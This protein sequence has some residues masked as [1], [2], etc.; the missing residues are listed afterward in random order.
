MDRDNF[1]GKTI[2]EGKEY[3]K[4]ERLGYHCFSKDHN[5]KDCESKYRCRIEYCNKRHHSLTCT[6]NKIKS[7]QVESE[8]I[9]NNSIPSNKVYDGDKHNN[10]TYMQILPINLSNGDKTFR[11]NALLDLGSDST[12]IS[13]TLPDKLN[14]C[15]AERSLTKT[16]VSR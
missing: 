4:S 8:E 5:V 13:K 9:A 6:G 1:K 14:I 10:S 11:A 7:N 3:N 16:R 15:G 2:D 12:L